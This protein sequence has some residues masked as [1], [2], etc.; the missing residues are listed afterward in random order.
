MGRSARQVYRIPR[1]R[2]V[3][4]AGTTNWPPSFP[5]T[6]VGKGRSLYFRRS[7]GRS[8]QALRINCAVGVNGPAGLKDG[9]VFFR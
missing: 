8:G 2:R 3:L 6:D 4:R 9:A 1:P 5:V 7:V